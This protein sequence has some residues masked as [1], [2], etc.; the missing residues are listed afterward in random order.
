MTTALLGNEVP[1]CCKNA[2]SSG[3]IS[4]GYVRKIRYPV[5]IHWVRI[6]IHSKRRIRFQYDRSR[7]HPHTDPMTIKKSRVAI[8]L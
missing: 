5:T 8:I 6:M 7:I 3:V 4:E 1:I 2:N